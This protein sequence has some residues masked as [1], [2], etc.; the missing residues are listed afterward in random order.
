MD[1]TGM[2]VTSVKEEKEHNPRLS[3]SKAE[4]IEIMANLNLAYP[5]LIVHVVQ[6]MINM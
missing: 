2:T 4:F 3:K 5:K 1:D 6:A